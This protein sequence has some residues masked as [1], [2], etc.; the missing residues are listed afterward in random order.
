[1]LNKSEMA[2]FASSDY[3]NL[4]ETLDKSSK[5]IYKYEDVKHRLCK[6]AFDVVKFLPDHDNY[7][8]GLWQIQNTDDGEVIVARYKDEP[9]MKSESS[10][11]AE[12]NKAATE[13]TI[14]HNNCP[15]KV[16]TASDLGIKGEDLIKF[17]YEIPS[18]IESNAKLKK[19]LTG[20]E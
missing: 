10:W 13:I 5:E 7:I 11:S 20:A 8:D 14:Y 6:V 4:E 16:V 15:V 3:Q 1:M 18:I 12:L 9:E 19:D 2:K 17:A